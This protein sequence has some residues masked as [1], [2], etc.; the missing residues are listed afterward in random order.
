MPTLFR[1]ALLCLLAAGAARAEDKP[2][3]IAYT[4]RF[5]PE[6][7]TALVSVDYQP[8]GGRIIALDFSMPADRYA[9]FEGEGKLEHADGR[10]KWTPPKGGGEVSWRYRIDKQRRSGGYDARIT[11]DWALLRGDHLVPPVRARLSKNSRARAL[12]RFELPPGWSGIDTPYKRRGES[13]M[14]DLVDADRRLVRPLGWMIAGDIGIR[15]EFIGDM[16]AA[17]AGP[18]GDPLR[19][20]EYLAYLNL[21][22]SELEEAF[23]RLPQKLLVVGA[24]DPMWRGGLSGPN[25]L[26]L[27]SDRPLISENGTS[28]FVH[29]L[30]HV[31]SRVRG[32][33]G[34]D[35]IAEGLAEYYSIELMRRVGLITESRADKAFSWMRNHGRNVKTL[36]ADRS[37]GPRTARAVGLFR[38]L[39]REIRQRSDDQYDIDDVSRRLVGRGRIGLEQLREAVEAVTG[40]PSSVLDTSLVR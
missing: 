34:D 25:S 12:L 6:R 3:D 18:K 38:A 8:A 2:F 29:E 32:A 33:R 31:I 30:V 22:S 11:E 26:Y 14:F 40:E 13:P 35:W 15:R 27:H 19:R 5:E 16:E 9:D 21:L 4:V 37:Y 17:V 36:K 20:N 7:G 10:L 39:D 24:G 1:L 28:T 23:G